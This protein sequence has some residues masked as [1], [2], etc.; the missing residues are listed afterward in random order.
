MELPDKPPT[1]RITESGDWA[2]FHAAR[3]RILSISDVPAAD[4]RLGV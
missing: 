3:L 1:R 2:F 4:N